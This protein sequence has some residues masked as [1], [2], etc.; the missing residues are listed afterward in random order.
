MEEQN[1]VLLDISF[2][3]WTGDVFF[4]E[5]A[6]T[7]YKVSAPKGSLL[8]DFLLRWI[9][10]RPKVRDFLWDVDDHRLKA[11]VMVVL[12]GRYQSPHE[13]TELRDGDSLTLIQVASG[14]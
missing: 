6:E 1:T 7:N 13:E 10:E 5:G 14:G 9:Q 4:P 12:N 2:R 11:D 8:W 3:G